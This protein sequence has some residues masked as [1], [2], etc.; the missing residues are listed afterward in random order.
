MAVSF[1]SDIAARL[2]GKDFYDIANSL[3]ARFARIKAATW[4]AMFFGH[5]GR[6][7]WLK[8][9]G[10]IYGP[11]RIR[12]GEEV[13]IEEGVTL[14]SVKRIAG[15]AYD[16]AIRIG[17]R[18]FMN[19]NCNVT[20]AFGVSIGSDVAFGPSVFVTDFDHDF[21]DPGV[22]RLHTP[23]VSKGPVEIG[24]RCWIGA[25]VCVTSGVVLGAGCVV[26][27]NSVVTRSFPANTVVAGI[28]A[29]AISC[30]DESTGT[31]IPAKSHR[32]AGNWTAA[33][34]E[35]FSEESST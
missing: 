6:G 1:A 25:N 20:A 23:L 31:W 29:E 21:K 11:G 26:G 30:L 35:S 7:C 9:P 13:R 14:Y 2:R 33:G 4:Y 18:T 28:P 8:R 5:I 19:R 17:D 10:L 22:G 24:D 12:L 16:G 3:D 15:Q 27:A 32:N 34:P